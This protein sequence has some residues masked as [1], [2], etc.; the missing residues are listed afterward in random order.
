MQEQNVLDLVSRIYDTALDPE[1]WSTVLLDIAITL[2]ASGSMI[3]ELNETNGIQRIRTPYQSKNY[4]PIAVQ[5]YLRKH[6]AQELIDQAAFAEISGTGEDINLFDDIQFN[7]SKDDLLKQSNVRDMMAA[8]LKHRSGTVLNKDSWQ[9]DRFALQYS[10]KRGPSTSQEKKVAKVILPHV[11]KALRIGRPLLGN[12]NVQATFASRL[13]RL[14]FGLCVISPKGFPISTNLEFD[15]IAETTPVFKYLS[16]GQLIMTDGAGLESYTALMENAEIHGKTGAYPR[17][18][19]IFLP[20]DE[21]D[22]GYFIEICPISSNS[23]Y[24]RLP[25]KS[26]LITVLDSNRSRQLDSNTM[27]KFFPLSKSEQL[28]LELIGFGHTNKEIADIRN[29]SE[30]TINSQVKSLLFKTYTKNR[31][32]LVQLALSIEA[33]FSGA[34][35]GFMSD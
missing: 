33:P 32:E 5:A 17:R 12:G 26:R 21:R 10:N 8:G 3:F 31:T 7:L 15:R 22:L 23:E 16:T 9:I 19:S 13:D 24:G 27:A 35:T 25:E 2:G 29:R 6:N 30:E 18:Q 34:M 4:D 11:A 1:T 28:V 20:S 14:P